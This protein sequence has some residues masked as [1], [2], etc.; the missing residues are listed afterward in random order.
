MATISPQKILGKWSSGVAL[1]VH[2]TSSTYL[3]VDEFGHERFDNKRSEIGELLYRLKYNADKSAADE[4]VATAV[5]FLTPYKA[6][7]ELIVPVPPS[8]AR[9]V[10]PV[11][12]M[13]NGI[14]AA[15][16][17]PVNDCIK[18]T[19]DP[20]QLKNVSDPAKRKEL[21]AGL[22]VVDP[23]FTTGKNILLFDDLFR[24]GSTMN[25]I[26]DVMMQVGK[27]ANVRVFTITRT[28][29]SQ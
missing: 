18:T 7:F 17:I 6:K 11:I 16:G 19:R 8:I 12:L 9:A 23:I 28:R 15:L 27:T 5:Q 3:G 26:T 20:T 4:I 2:T 14:G 24:S 10:Q 21:L 1:D 13:A 25:A 29:S 22:Y